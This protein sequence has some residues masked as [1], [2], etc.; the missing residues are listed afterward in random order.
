MSKTKVEEI[1]AAVRQLPKKERK[2]LFKSLQG[3][4]DMEGQSVN[5]QESTDKASGTYSPDQLPPN[6]DLEMK[7][8]LDHPEFWEQH[9]GEHVALWGYKMIAVGKTR[10]EVVAQARA[11]GIQFPFVQYLPGDQHEW[12]LGLSN[13]PLAES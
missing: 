13:Q 1:L 4:A 5:S 2:R 6:R 12:L 9:R 11:R 7:W 3:E 10:K 8:L